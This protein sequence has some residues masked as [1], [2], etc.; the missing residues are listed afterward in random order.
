MIYYILKMIE[1]IDKK[2]I[3]FLTKQVR[4]NTYNYTIKYI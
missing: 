3:Q 1:E 2:F 4:S